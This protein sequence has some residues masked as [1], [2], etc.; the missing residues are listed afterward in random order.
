MRLTDLETTIE[1]LV[2]ANTNV[3]GARDRIAARY[4]DPKIS[5]H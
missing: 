4:S 3:D 1:L 5:D 2:E